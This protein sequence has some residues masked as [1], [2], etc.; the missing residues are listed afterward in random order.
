MMNYYFFKIDKMKT[1]FC[2]RWY[3]YVPLIILVII[4]IGFLT[5]G[6]W[7]WLMPLLFHLPEITIWQTAGLMLLARLL[8]GG[9]GGHHG[10]HRH[11]ND[12]NHMRSHLF[13]KW[14]NM[15]PEE[16]EK[17]RENIRMHRTPWT[18]NC[19]TED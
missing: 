19:Q 13:E 15:T 5:M 8:L 3:F 7:N 12:G 2:R 9:F 16:R 4:G 14:E 11:P 10:H 17:F 6:L 1:H 18:K